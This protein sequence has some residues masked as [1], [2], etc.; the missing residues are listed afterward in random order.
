MLAIELSGVHIKR[1]MQITYR[2]PSWPV[3]RPD[4]CKHVYA[5]TIEH[6][7]NGHVY[8]KD[9]ADYTIGYVPFDGVVEFIDGK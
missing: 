8:F 9:A 7:R 3:S 2:F 6:H 1:K 5:Y 4:A